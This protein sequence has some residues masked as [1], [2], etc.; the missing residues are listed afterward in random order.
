VVTR[1]I[2]RSPSSVRRALDG[3]GKSFGD[4]RALAL[5]PAGLLRYEAP[6]AAGDAPGRP[7]WQARARLY[8]RGP[9]LS[10]YSR[11]DVE[12]TAWSGGACE[13]HLRPVARR[14]ATRGVRRQRRYFALAHQAADEL[15]ES[16]MA[17]TSDPRRVAVLRAEST[18]EREK[19]THG[20]HRQ[21]DQDRHA[22]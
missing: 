3:G 20:I 10:R 4:D 18:R 6:F 19:S 14:L 11:V 7:S 9:R 16:L 21:T 2:E 15:V 5:P 17:A 1:R 22:S 13:L 12:I 8:G